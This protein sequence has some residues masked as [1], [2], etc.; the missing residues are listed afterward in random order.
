MHVS[1]VPHAQYQGVLSEMIGQTDA[2]DKDRAID[3]W[4]ARGLD[5]SR[6]FHK[7]NVPKSV[8]THHCETQDHGLDKV[9]DNKLIAFA[10]SAL[11]TR[12]PVMEDVKIKNVDR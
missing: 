1:V 5:V 9:L 10:K 6:M 3:H 11:D 4:K 2:L 8:A 7:P 12:K